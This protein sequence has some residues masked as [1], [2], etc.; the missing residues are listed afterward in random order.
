M[1]PVADELKRTVEFECVNVPLFVHEPPTVR[2][3]MS[4][5]T[6]VEPEPMSTLPETLV[7]GSLVF[8]VTVT[9]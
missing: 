2:A 9:A 3:P 1:F 5:A 6:K 8:A 4:D 7:E